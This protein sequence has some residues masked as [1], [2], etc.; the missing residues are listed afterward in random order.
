MA[1]LRIQ[2]IGTSE[3]FVS[4]GEGKGYNKLTVTYKNLATNPPKVEV[5]NLMDFANQAVYEKLK[6][7]EKDTVLQVTSEKINNFWNWTEVHR[8]DGPVPQAVAT[9][10]SS[11][12]APAKT[13]TYEVNNMIQQER[14]KH[15]IEKQPLIIRQSCI[16]SAVAACKAGTSVED[17]LKVAAE[18][19][20]WV[21]GKS[22]T[23]MHDDVPY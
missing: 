12:G 1:N 20:N 2:V 4:K 18:F 22:L 5:K 13:N 21:N 23:Q 19:E 11:G 8:D 10:A 9:P 15:D 6:G 17:I 16:S 3:E 7:T 14:L